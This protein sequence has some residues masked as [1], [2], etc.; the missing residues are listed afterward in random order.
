MVWWNEDKLKLIKHDVLNRLC[1]LKSLLYLK[2]NSL[3]GELNGA[4]P[5]WKM[6]QE[7]K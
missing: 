4:R 2:M 5:V 1:M 7:V 3:V 6:C